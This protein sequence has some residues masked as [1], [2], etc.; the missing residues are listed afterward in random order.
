MRDTYSRARG[1]RL[2]DLEYGYG[3]VVS[4]GDHVECRRGIKTFGGNMKASI[5]LMAWASESMG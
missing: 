4:S 2:D 5:E 3:N 1:E